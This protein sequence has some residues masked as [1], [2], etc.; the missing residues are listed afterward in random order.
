MRCVSELACET[1]GE[2]T[3]GHRTT[4]P[5]PFLYKGT[6][7][8]ECDAGYTLP[9]KGTSTINCV[10]KASD[11]K[12]YLEWDHMPT[13]CKGTASGMAKLLEHPAR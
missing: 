6:C 9:D 4:C 3:N 10:V 5:E 8:F 2:Q 11:G 13:A 1:P 7:Q 12:F